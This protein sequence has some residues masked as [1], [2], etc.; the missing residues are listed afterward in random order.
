M[1]IG[2]SGGDGDLGLQGWFSPPF[3]FFPFFIILS[4]LRRRANSNSKDLVVFHFC[5]LFIFGFLLFSLNC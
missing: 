3:E 2:T 1:F 4:F 5:L